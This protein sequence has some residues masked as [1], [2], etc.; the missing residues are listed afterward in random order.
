MNYDQR[1]LAPEQL[2]Y[3]PHTPWGPWSGLLG[4]VG[5]T[6]HNFGD[7][8]AMAAQGWLVMIA[9]Q[10]VMTACAW[11]LAGWFGGIRTRVLSLAGTWPSMK[12]MAVILAVFLSFTVPYTWA[13]YIFRPD[14]LIADNAM[15][16]SLM[17]SAEWP[18]YAFIIAVGAPVSEEFLF[19]GFM[20]PAL[21]K[22]RIGFIGATVV[23]TLLWMSLHFNYS[24]FG[25]IEIFVIGLLLSW[26]LRKTGSLW[27][28]IALHAINNGALA[29]AMKYQLLPWT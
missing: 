29:F 13:I 26:A 21:A 14:V 19:R 10:A 20:L 17:R 4:G 6:I 7:Q 8:Q 11:W 22:S 3:E 15:F 9:F 28:P 27:A 12:D 2:A 16:A 1:P 5:A 18:V 23:T 25:L 24:I